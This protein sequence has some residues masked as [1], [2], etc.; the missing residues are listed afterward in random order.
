MR[1]CHL[2]RCP[3]ILYWSMGSAIKNKYGKR[4]KSTGIIAKVKSQKLKCQR[5]KL[6]LIPKALLS[7]NRQ[8]WGR[9]KVKDTKENPI[10][11]VSSCKIGKE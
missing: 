11:L 3:R 8:V 9:N 10:P 2:D 6:K 1:H 7:T 5:L 4:L